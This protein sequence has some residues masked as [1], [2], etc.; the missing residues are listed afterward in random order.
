[1]VQT[2]YDIIKADGGEL[3]VETNE[4]AGTRFF[5]NILI[6]YVDHRLNL[7]LNYNLSDISA[8]G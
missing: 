8:R 6:N 7:K 2:N 3:K 4:G 1:M 5:F